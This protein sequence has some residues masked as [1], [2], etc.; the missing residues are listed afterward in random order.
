M[1]LSSVVK[2]TSMSP[3]L[4]P[5]PHKLFTCPPGGGLYTGSGKD[6]SAMFEGGKADPELAEQLEVV[7][8]EVK[9]LEIESEHQRRAKKIQVNGRNGTLED[10]SEQS[11]VEPPNSGHT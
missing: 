7:Q 2:L 10:G 1:V 8:K 3:P 9:Q 4:L 5:G 6:S 11:M